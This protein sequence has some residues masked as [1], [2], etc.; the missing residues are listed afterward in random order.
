MQ[1]LANTVHSHDT[2]NMAIILNQLI[3]VRLVVMCTGLPTAVQVVPTYVD[4]QWVQ[5]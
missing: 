5:F 1:P 3:E 2:R 4:G